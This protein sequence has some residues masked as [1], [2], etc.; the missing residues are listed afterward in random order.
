MCCLIRPVTRA[1]IRTYA[2]Y[3]DPYCTRASAHVL[4]VWTRP[5]ACKSKRALISDLYRTRAPEQALSFLTRI[6]CVYQYVYSHSARTV[7]LLLFLI[8]AL[9]LAPVCND[10]ALR[11]GLHTHNYIRN[12]PFLR[13]VFVL[14]R[15]VCFDQK[16]L[17]RPNVFVL[18]KLCTQTRTC[19][20]MIRTHIML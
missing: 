8:L 14:T 11:A 17:F 4:S 16:W 15:S 9:K 2:L 13:S 1:C 5:H 7:F 12:H 6:K 20:E 18:T 3:L 10:R 19:T